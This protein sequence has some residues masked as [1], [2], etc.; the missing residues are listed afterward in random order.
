MPTTVPRAGVIQRHPDGM[1]HRRSAARTMPAPVIESVL[2]FFRDWLERFVDV[3]GIDRAMAIAA[4]SYSAFLPL[5]IVYAATLP[6]GDNEELRRRARQPLRAQRR[7]RGERAAGVRA[8]RAP[9]S[10]ASRCSAS[11]CCWSRTLSFTRGLQRLYELAF[12]LPTL[13]MRNTPRALMW[14]LSSVAVLVTLRPIVTEPVQRRG[15]WSAVTLVDRHRA[16]ARDALPAAR[17]P[18]CAPAAP[19][20]ER[21]ADRD[22]HGR[23]RRSGR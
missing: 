13:G 18:A 4:Q 14:L 19:A 8:R 5:V 23:H 7:D 6:R 10:R 9:W 20:A 22:R 12:G 1:R 16:V 15:C 2:Q 3:Q 17:A 21:A 11:C